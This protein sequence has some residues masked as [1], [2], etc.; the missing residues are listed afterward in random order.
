M[1]WRAF[2]GCRSCAP[3]AARKALA[4]LFLL[5]LL[6]LLLAALP[7][8]ADATADCPNEAIRSAQGPA[9]L[10]LPD[11]R[12]YELVTPAGKGSGEPEPIDLGEAREERDTTPLEPSHLLPANGARADLAGERFAWISEPLPGDAVPGLSHL[13]TR[14]PAGWQSLGLTPPLSPLN[15]LLCPLLLGVSAYSSDLRTSILDLPAGAPA[16]FHQEE[17]CGHDEPRLL[18]GEPEHF[19]NLYRHDDISGENQLVNL[20]PP[21]V[22]WPEPEADGQ[23]YWPASYL[24][25]SDDLDHVVFEEELALT[26]DAP[27]GYPGGNE[28][29]EWHAGGVH[30]V[31]I[32]PDGT[33]THG[34][35]AGAT[36]NYSAPS[37]FEEQTRN[38][39]Q[40]RNAVSADGS[41][42]FFEAAGNLYVR[43]G[44][45][46]TRQ[47]D[48]SRGPDPG[49]GGHF[50]AASSTGTLVLFTD[51]ERLTPDST[52][53]PGSHD[54]YELD[55]ASDELTDLTPDSAQPADVLGLAGVSADGAYVYAVATGVLDEKANSFGE[56]A[57]AG[58]PNLYL[59]GAGGARFIATLAPADEC[60]WSSETNCAGGGFGSGLTSRTT[61]TGSFIAFNSIRPLAGYDNTDAKSGEPDIEIYRYDAHSDR[62]LC[63]SCNPAD[64]RPLAGAAIHWPA[65]PG[66]NNNWSN[67]YPQRN[68]AEDGT[69]FFETAD[70][71]LPVD[72]NARRD[73]YE[74]AGAAPELLSSG[75]SEA[76]SHFLDVTPDGTNVFISTAERLLGSDEDEVYDYY[77]ARTD[78][79]VPELQSPELGCEGASC[80]EAP[81]PIAPAQLP[82]SET[83]A[84]AAHRPLKCLR[85]H[86]PH[87]PRRCRKHH[88][89]ST[90]R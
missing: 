63:A 36:R 39:A 72:G 21:D 16:G 44:A 84:G 28:L 55:L 51:P 47:I 22:S 71:L 34:S 77:D 50:L 38:I 29:Y 78:G 5:A 49:G 30:L 70:P 64:T 82:G 86:R 26:P 73:V 61:T 19:R 43:E 53:S 42:I 57:S 60:D 27:L 24:A 90:R 66:D 7:A 2:T 25:A 20:T 1:A 79:G 87:R 81:P 80:R 14:G 62:L 11:C 46:K 35:L 54:L 67:A 75:A 59:L 58:E 17:E 4:S 9:A 48:A 76:S 89:R 32:L 31:T 45:S 15:D 74:F 33:P 12:A 41:R 52:A 18:A 6:V 10:A 56:A 83:L 69:V 40:F 13:A 23:L 37:L 88:K 68:L 8:A 85:G 65:N 3:D